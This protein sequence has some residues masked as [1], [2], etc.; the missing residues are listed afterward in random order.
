MMSLLPST[1]LEKT[2][3]EAHVDLCAMRYAQLDQR[4]TTIEHKVGTLQE[5]IEESKNSMAKVIIG[6]AGTIVASII[7]L[8]ITLLTK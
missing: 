2:S 8:I 6:S 1:D 7:A 3:L 4:L 5:I